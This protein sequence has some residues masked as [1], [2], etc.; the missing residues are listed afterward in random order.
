MSWCVVNS[1][2]N[3]DKWFHHSLPFIYLIVLSLRFINFDCHHQLKKDKNKRGYFSFYLYHGCCC[4][5]FFP[6]WLFFQTDTV[7]QQHPCVCVCLVKAF[8]RVISQYSGRFFFFQFC[9]FFFV[10]VVV[11][12]ILSWFHVIFFSDCL[13][14]IHSCCCCCCYWK[15]IKKQKKKFWK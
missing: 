14:S 15:W 13:A 4:L 5:I 10:V 3:N 1:N 8:D 12:N 7:Y 6:G 9:H 11:V 2:N